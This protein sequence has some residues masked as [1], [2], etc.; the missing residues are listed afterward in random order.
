MTVLTREDAK[1]ALKHVLVNVFGHAEDGPIAKALA[2]HMGEEPDIV[3]VLALST[4]HM[5]NLQYTN[6]KGKIV[7]LLPGH[8]GLLCALQ[9]YSL[10]CMAKG[11]PLETSGYKHPR[12]I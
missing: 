8:C 12:S 7:H 2:W 1:S 5:N 6:D 3:D 4:D 11:D 10:F 9:S